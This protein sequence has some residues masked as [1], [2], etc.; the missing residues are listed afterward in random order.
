MLGRL[1]DEVHADAGETLMEQ[2][3]QGYEFMMI[4]EGTAA[5]IRDGQQ[6]ASMGSGDFFGELSILSDGIP[7]TATVVARSPIRGLV[8][9]AHFLRELHDR[10]PAVGQRIEREARERLE[11]DARAAGG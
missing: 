11:R 4:E 5:V 2:G 6:I 8:F 9:T 7:R 3:S 1:L 10:I